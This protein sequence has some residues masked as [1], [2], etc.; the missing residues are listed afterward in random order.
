MPAV[1]AD[2]SQYALQSLCEIRGCD[3][4]T[5]TNLSVD[6]GGYKPALENIKLSLESGEL[7]VVLGLSSGKPLLNLIAGFVPYQRW[8]V[9]RKGKK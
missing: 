4:L 1:A 8:P 6:Y 5:I 9:N 7:L 3:A 2:Y